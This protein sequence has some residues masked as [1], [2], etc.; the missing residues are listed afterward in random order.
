[1]A[2]KSTNATEAEPQGQTPGDEYYDA[3]RAAKVAAGLSLE[4]ATEVTARQR[5]EDEANAFT[6]PDET[7]TP[8]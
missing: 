1:M 4:L 5:K 2:K 7:I 3:M 6:L 8:E